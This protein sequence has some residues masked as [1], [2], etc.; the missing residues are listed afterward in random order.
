MFT[1][2]KRLFSRSLVSQP[3]SIMFKRLSGACMGNTATAER[4]M[5]HEISLA[6][7]ISRADAVQRAY[8]RLL[9]DR[10]R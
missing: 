4:L 6:P 10:S 5:H 8:D 7:R 3:D 2:I 9:R 1:F